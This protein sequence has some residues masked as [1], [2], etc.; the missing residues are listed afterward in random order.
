MIGNLK[1]PG[2]DGMPTLFYKEYWEIMGDKI[3]DEVLQVL[4]G[5]EMPSR[6]NDTTIVLIPKVKRPENVKDLRPISLCN[7]VT[8]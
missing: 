7:V 5:G 4:Q 8:P 6:W 1:A 2:P 3:V